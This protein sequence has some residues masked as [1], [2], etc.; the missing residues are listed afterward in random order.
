M[1]KKVLKKIKDICRKDTAT[2]DA[3]KILYPREDKEVILWQIWKKRL[4]MIALVILGI[5]LL[6]LGCLLQTSGDSLLSEKKY[7]TRQEEDSSVEMTVKGDDGDEQWQEQMKVTVKQRQ[8]SEEEK[9]QL[10]KK[11]KAYVEKTLP[12]ENESLEHI[13]KPLCFVT[14]VPDTE[15]ELTWTWDED[16]IKE[17]GKLRQGKIPEEGVD[18]DIMLEASCRNWK[19]TFYFAGHLDSV[20][21]S[22]EQQEIKETKQA[23]KDSLKQQKE[24]QVVELP[25]KVGDVTLTYEPVEEEKSYLPVYAA[26]F[27]CLLIPLMWREN[28]KKQIKKRE[29]QM[30]LDHPGIVNKVMLLLSAGLT[31]RATIE[32]LTAEYERNR[33]NGGEVRYAYEELCIM[34]QEIRDG[35][36]EGKAMEDFGKRCRLQPYLRFSSIVAQN[37]KKGSEGIIDILEQESMEALEQRKEMALRQGETVGTKLLFPMM[38]MLG[39]VMGII[40]IPAFMTM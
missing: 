5:F 17:S 33:G 6:W 15:V 36:S 4:G 16:Y 2:A 35:K 29:E 39:L 34:I 19:K 12:G 25:E 22:K 1:K 13:T 27:V 3:V 7:I 8:F 32:R 24:S 30:L 20:E 38:I 28:Q 26:V 18:T 37:L 40:M 14:E 11:V 23:V 9:E 10:E 31:L 21:L